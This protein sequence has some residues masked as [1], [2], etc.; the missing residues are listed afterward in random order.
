LLITLVAHPKSEDIIQD[1]KLL[2]HDRVTL[3]SVALKKIG[4]LRLKLIW[5]EPLIVRFSSKF[6]VVHCHHVVKLVTRER[7]W[8]FLWCLSFIKYESIEI[9]ILWRLIL[10]FLGLLIFVRW[11][12]IPFSFIE[13]GTGIIF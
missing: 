10:L 9:C 13:S 8:T 11:A 3:W 1:L 4:E 2:V 6:W 7:R 5:N 12:P